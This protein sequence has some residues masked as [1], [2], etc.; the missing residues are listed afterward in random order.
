MDAVGSVRRR[1]RPGVTVHPRADQ[2]H[3]TSGRRLRRRAPL[4]PPRRRS[5]STSK[6]IRD[7]ICSPSC[8]EIGRTSARSCRSGQVRSR[9]RPGGRRHNSG[10][11]GADRR[12]PARRGIRVSLFVEADCGASSG[13]RRWGR[14]RRAVYRALRPGVQGAARPPNELSHGYAE[15]AERAHGDR[16]RRQRR[17]RPRPRQPHLFRT[18]PHLAEVSIGH[19]LISHALFVGLETRRPGLPGARLNC[20]GVIGEQDARRRA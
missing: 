13:P 17:A 9:A 7:P 15:A 16:P 1:G 2:R 11:L 4:R 19:A 20:S 5:S 12:R 14:P 8:I 6:G 18:L 10:E 3:I